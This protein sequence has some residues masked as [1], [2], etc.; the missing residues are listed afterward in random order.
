[1]SAK[2]CTC[3][4]W[5][6]TRLPCPYG[7]VNILDK[8]EPIKDYVVDYY[9]V[10]TYKNIYFYY[11]NTT[12][13][14]DHWNEVAGGGDVLPSN[15]IKKKKRGRE[16]MARRNEDE[17]LEKQRGVVAQSAKDKRAEKKICRIFKKG[18]I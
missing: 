8:N 1:M 12:G 15:F 3:T 10:E 6:L 11:I 4:R 9:K 13:P 17:E 14:E 16:T 2:T 7:V 18:N 5:N